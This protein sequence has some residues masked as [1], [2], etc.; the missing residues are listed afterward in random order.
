MKVPFA[1]QLTVICVDPSAVPFKCVSCQT[2]P[3]DTPHAAEGV[4]SQG[5]TLQTLNIVHKRT[6]MF[7]D[8]NLS[9]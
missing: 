4:A 9:M 6:E 2:R 3:E 7:K 1:W 8:V 5:V